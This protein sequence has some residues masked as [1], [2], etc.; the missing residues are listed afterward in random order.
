MALKSWQIAHNKFLD[1]QIEQAD[2]SHQ[3]RQEEN[4]RKINKWNE[5][6]EAELKKNPDKWIPQSCPNLDLTP[7]KIII[8]IRYVE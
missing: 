2:Y 5:Y 7:R 3:R 8:G 6:R 4:N 1:L